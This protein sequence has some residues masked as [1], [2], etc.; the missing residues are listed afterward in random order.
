MT[1]C[2]GK[3]PACGISSSEIPAIAPPVNIQQLLTHAREIVPMF[4]RQAD[5]GVTAVFRVDPHEGLVTMS[6]D[7]CG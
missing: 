4:D 1:H 7:F 5:T 6:P 2:P 3:S